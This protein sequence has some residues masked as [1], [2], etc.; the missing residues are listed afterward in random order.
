MIDQINVTVTQAPPINAV[1]TPP[2]PINVAF[3][4]AQGLPGPPG[5]IPVGVSFE[6]VALIDGAQ[7]FT[8]PSPVGSGWC[9]LAINGLR[10]SVAAYSVTGAILT[11]PSALQVLAGDLISFDYYPSN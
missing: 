7:V 3:T 2:A 9:L 5:T 1:I 10:Q 6:T 8:L 11:L 4:Q